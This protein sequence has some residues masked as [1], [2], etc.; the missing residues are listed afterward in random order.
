MKNYW[1]KKVANFHPNKIGTL[2]TS[3]FFSVIFRLFH[4]F[5]ENKLV[6]DNRFQCAI[7]DL[8]TLRQSEW[9]IYSCSDAHFLA[10][11]NL[12]CSSFSAPRRAHTLNFKTE[13]GIVCWQ[14]I[15]S[16]IYLQPSD[17]I[18]DSNENELPL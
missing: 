7:R 3:I 4:F 6:H 12:G 18:E 2:I 8:Y 1:T 15:M 10:K 14:L 5:S 16:E 11:R 13:I 17:V 9:D